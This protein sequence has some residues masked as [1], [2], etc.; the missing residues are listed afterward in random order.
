M[1][2]LHRCSTAAQ[3]STPHPLCLALLIYGSTASLQNRSTWDLPQ[4]EAKPRMN[5]SGRCGPQTFNVFLT[6]SLS[7]VL[8]TLSLVPGPQLT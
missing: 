3:R 2:A 8:M 6:Q 1:A 5:S 4:P 7:P